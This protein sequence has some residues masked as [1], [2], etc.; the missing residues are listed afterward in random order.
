[1]LPILILLGVIGPFLTF[2][3]LGSLIYLIRKPRVKV[4][5]EEGPRVA[6]IGGGRPADLPARAAA[7]PAPRAGL[8]LRARPL[9]AATGSCWR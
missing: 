5:F 1:M 7:L 3:M 6:E 2:T 4:A 9:R 8:P